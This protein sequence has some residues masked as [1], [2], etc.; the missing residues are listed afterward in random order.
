MSSR[1][2]G[3]PHR[4]PQIERRELL[5]VGSVGLFGISLPGVLQAAAAQGLRPAAAKSCILLFLDG[6]PGQQDMWDMK[7]D[8]PA[9]IRGE[10]KPIATSVPE[11][12]VCEG[13]PMVSQQMHHLTLIRSVTHDCNIHSAATYY[14]LTGRNPSPKG[15]LIIKEEPDNF[16]PFGS[17]LA[18]L[19]P[20]HDV[21][22]VGL[23]PARKRA[24][25]I[26]TP[27]PTEALDNPRF[28][29]LRVGII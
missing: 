16:P 27:D 26:R 15:T 21:L 29:R 4:F 9:D 20:R 10:F 8:A 25:R 19:Q 24:S 11:I 5:K 12:Q 23:P 6:G 17:V 28:N 1:N 13:L 7:P 18:K 14:M 22:D 3:N 2:V